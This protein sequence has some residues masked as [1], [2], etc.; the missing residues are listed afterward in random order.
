MRL[1]SF[2]S[3]VCALVGVGIVGLAV[4]S[5]C[6]ISEN[7]SPY[8]IDGGALGAC[9]GQEAREIPASSCPKVTCCSATAF[10]LCLGTSYSDC[11]CA[12]L[13]GYTLV[14]AAGRPV[15]ADI[16]LGGECGSPDSGA[17]GPSEGGESA[18]HG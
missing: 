17:D 11:S 7:G 5:A 14:N 16:D 10:A 13:D 4:A 18:G 2:H 3:G 15:D 1:R 12:L 6:L 8:L 9:S